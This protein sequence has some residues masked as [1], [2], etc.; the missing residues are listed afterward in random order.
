PDWGIGSVQ[1]DRP[2]AGEALE[3]DASGWNVPEIL[4]QFRSAVDRFGPDAVIISDAWNMKPLLAAA[5]RG[6]RTY[7]RFQ[8]LEC[9]CPLN[10]LRLLAH[11]PEEIEQ[12]P[13]HQLATPQVCHRCLAERGAHSGALHRWERAL[14]GVG[15]PEYDQ[16][17]RRALEEA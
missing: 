11:G 14:A 5:V 2:G 10:N 6:Y 4:A 1:A 12:C 17:L 8:A 3:F 9:L 7:L 15:T 16:L 13:R